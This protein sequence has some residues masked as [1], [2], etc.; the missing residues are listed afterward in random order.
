M[1]DNSIAIMW[2]RQ[3]LRTHDNPA[4]ALAQQHPNILPIYIFDA[5]HSS[6]MPMGSASKVY[7]HHALKA[8]NDKLNGK[9]NLYSGDYLTVI[10]NLIAKHNISAIYSNI[11]FEPAVMTADEHIKAHCSA[12]NIIFA[13]ENG[14]FIWHPQSVLKDATEHYKVFTPFKKKA[15]TTPVRALAPAPRLDN[16]ISD[17]G[18]ETLD[19]LSLLPGHKWQD[20]LIK[21]WDFGEDAAM[22]KV[23]TFIQTRLS[24]YKEGR[25]LPG[26]DHT[27]MIS[28][29]LHFG[30]LSPT[31]VWHAASVQ[32]P[33]YAN[34]RDI[35]HYLSEL[36]W[37]EFS[38]YLLYYFNGLASENFN[39]RFDAFPWAENNEL[40]R[41]WQLGQTGIP[42]VDAGMRQLYQTGYM[43]NRVRMITASFLVKNLMLHWRHG[44]DWFW[45]CLV[46]ADYANNAAS[47]QWVAGSGADA[48]PY[49]RIFNPILQGQKFDPDGTY[50]RKY[51][52]ELKLMPK[53]FLF[54]PW[55]APLLVLQAAE[56]NL[57]GNY[58][59]P[60]VDL[61]KSRD[62]AL[63]AYSKI[64]KA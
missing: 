63:N 45:D 61:A 13:Q 48:A 47:W 56:V 5:E 58:P 43:H 50:T 16:L 20:T 36:T 52:P 2:Y 35:E 22:K 4:L 24:G 60:I 26:I 18:A 19:Q 51:V 40:L 23:E 6:G 59:N 7:L 25:N 1:T 8:L 15:F 44:F 28:A 33:Q 39:P 38:T 14:C 34:D 42:I 62:S 17:E 54:K 37:R 32:G 11:G 12:N 27:S 10:S 41:K 55:E 3:D 9:L 29:N 46:D 53:E 64:K 57:G 30:E 49:F 31:W 21:T